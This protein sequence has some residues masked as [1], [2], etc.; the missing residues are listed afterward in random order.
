MPI[1]FR[2]Q[3]D[4]Q[5]LGNAAFLKLEEKTDPPGYRAALFQINARG[6]PVEFTYN[7]VDTP[8]TFL[9]RPADVKLAAGR[10]LAASLLKLSPRAP[11]IILC[12]AEEIPSEIFGE[13]IA[14]ALP[15]CRIARADF[16]TAAAV[17]LNEQTG[18]R[19]PLQFLWQPAPP[20]DD[21]PERLLFQQLV[22]HG[23]LLEPFERASAGLDELYGEAHPG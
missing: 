21:T 6:E 23:L 7:R 22:V 14:V 3:E 1:P 17:D 4:L 19:V 20:D 13:D 11:R 9:W 8:N 16:A 12:L 15:V 10:Q 2:D 18:E 5:N